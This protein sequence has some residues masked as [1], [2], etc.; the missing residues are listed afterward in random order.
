MVYHKDQYLA[1]YINDLA[2]VSNKLFSL[3]FADNS[4]M[5]ITGKN[6]DDI[7]ETMNSET[8]KY[9]RFGIDLQSLRRAHNN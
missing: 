3:L 5:F 6:I 8:K 4:N 7:I 1:L 9:Y 2:D